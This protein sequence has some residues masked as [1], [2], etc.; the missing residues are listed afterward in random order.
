[1]S[2]FIVLRESGAALPL[3][4]DKTTMT[5]TRLDPESARAIE[6]EPKPNQS[7]RPFEGLD[8]A[9]AVQYRSSAPARMFY[10]EDLPLA[11]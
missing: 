11:G 5:V 7:P 3:L 1:M 9:F 4:I 8:Y 2:R 6:G 10:R